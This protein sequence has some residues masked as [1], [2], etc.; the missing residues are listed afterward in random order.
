MTGRRSKELAEHWVEQHPLQPFSHR[1]FIA[2][3]ISDDLFSTRQDYAE[4]LNRPREQ[5]RPFFSEAL[6]ENT[7][8]PTVWQETS[9]ASG[10]IPSKHGCNKP[11]AGANP[12]AT[13]HG[14]PPNPSSRNAPTKSPPPISTPAAT[15]KTFKKPPSASTPKACCPPVNWV[16]CG[17]R[18]SK[19]QP[20]A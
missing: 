10:K 9:S 17:S 4:A 2:D 14:N 15:T 7:P 1:Y 6:E 19:P 18:I 11:W 3:K 16:N 5:V 13:K 8:V 12:I 20:N